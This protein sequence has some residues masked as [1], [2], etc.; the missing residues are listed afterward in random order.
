MSRQPKK[1]RNKH[2]LAHAYCRNKQKGQN[3][4]RASF[5]SQGPQAAIR[6]KSDSDLGMVKSDQQ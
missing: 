5:G 4:N 3:E 2:A 1:S 6:T